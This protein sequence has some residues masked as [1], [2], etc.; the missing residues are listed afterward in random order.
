MI[1]NEAKKLK[2]EDY[3]MLQ[4]IAADKHK[5]EQQE[6]KEKQEEL[7]VSLQLAWDKEKF[8][9][10]KQ[11]RVQDKRIEQMNRW[12]AEG[13]SVADVGLLLEMSGLAHP[14]EPSSLAQP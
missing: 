4:E 12:L 14:K 6:K 13:K 10:E 1:E 3:R 5:Q 9:H 7:A 11:E 8:L 2:N